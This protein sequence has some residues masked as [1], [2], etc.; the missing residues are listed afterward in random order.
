MSNFL[1]PLSILLD[2]NVLT[3]STYRAALEGLD[4]SMVEIL[5]KLGYE[6][7]P[8][9]ALFNQPTDARLAQ[10]KNK[11][12]RFHED[13]R[14]GMGE[15]VQKVHR[16]LGDFFDV[17]YFG[18]VMDLTATSGGHFDVNMSCLLSSG[19]SDDKASAKKKFEEQL[20]R[21]ND[22]GIAVEKYPKMSHWQM[23]DNDANKAVILETLQSKGASLIYITGRNGYISEIKFCLKPQ[24]VANFET[25]PTFQKI[26]VTDELN[27]DE[28]IKIRKNISEIISSLAFIKSDP[29][30]L[31]TCSFIA[32]SCFSEICECV[33]FEG[34][35]STRCKE[36]HAA[37]RAANLGIREIE[38]QIGNEFPVDEFAKTITQ[39]HVDICYYLAY[40]LHSVIRN[41]SI[42]QWGSGKFTMKWVT[43]EDEFMYY[44][45][46]EEFDNGCFPDFKEYEELFKISDW[47]GVGKVLLDAGNNMEMV[48]DFIQTVPGMRVV[49]YKVKTVGSKPYMNDLFVIDEVEVVID[50]MTAMIQWYDKK[51]ETK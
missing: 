13:K 22:M 18:R 5:D 48:K 10:A 9:R 17:V 6:Y 27:E 43:N 40:N 21:L 42:D 12:I 15:Y 47:E 24:D 38:A 2:M 7:Q 19:F 34:K 31:N 50:D 8:P 20:Q 25:Q 49:S 44:L 39:L 45:D 51:K 3:K 30:M 4:L 41:F 11:L 36:R 46:A 28:I 29:K 32:E 1:T 26:A 14:V 33:G 35:I 37:E 23:L 16:T